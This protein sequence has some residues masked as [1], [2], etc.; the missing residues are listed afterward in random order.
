MLRRPIEALLGLV[1]LAGIGSSC[2]LDPVHTSQ[3]DALG[4]EDGARYP[5]ESEYHRPGEPCALCHSDKGPAKSTFA[6]GGTVFW[7][8]DNYSN[9]VDNAYVRVLDATKTTRCFVTNCNGNF[10]VKTED[11]A[12]ITYPLL[13]SV[14][15][16]TT[17]GSG[18][19]E[20]TKVIRRMSSHVGR[21]PSC[22]TCHIQG[23]RDFGSPGQIRMYNT[24]DEVKT[25][26]I[27]VAA[28]PPEGN[29]TVV[30]QCP[31]DRTQ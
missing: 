23:L 3:V 8:P 20:P 25:N 14:E 26:N 11:F 2:N 16:T 15:R 6:L 9:R 17:P 18:P 21:E 19:V 1:L 13:I 31:E 27:T 30:T 5:T 7:G 4:A 12:K 29:Q 28:C 10:Y 24:E 22:A